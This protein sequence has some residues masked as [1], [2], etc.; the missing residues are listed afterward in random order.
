MEI[1]VNLINS[2]HV[3]YTSPIWEDVYFVISDNTGLEY[4]DYRITIGSSNEIIYRG[5]VY[6]NSHG[7]YPFRFKINDICQDYLSSH[8]ILDDEDDIE[9]YVNNDYLKGFVLQLSSNN[10]NTSRTVA[11]INFRYDWSYI[12][13]TGKN[14]SWVT[15]PI[16]NVVDYRQYF[17][18]SFAYDQSV[19]NNAVITINGTNYTNLNNP[20]ELTF[21]KRLDSSKKDYVIKASYGSYS[22]EYN[23]IDSCK[24]YCLYY[25]NERGGYDWLVID[26]KVVKSYNYQRNYF[27]QNYDSSSKEF[28]KVNYKN[29]ITESWALTT[30]YLSDI[31]SEKMR[32]IF[33]STELYLH[34]LVDDVITPVVITNTEQV[35]KT[36]KNQDRKLYNYTINVQNS[37]TKI[38]M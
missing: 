3:T 18:Y 8:L 38:R 34:D 23:V 16:S 1:S 12:H 2:P 9:F 28:G 25:L 14:V 10:F 21:V 19:A 6:R 4:I 35:E 33:G 30:G 7:K 26:G 22:T 32:N 31:Q 11:T 29:N 17:I 36:F 13:Y 15:N 27:T 24:R 37:Q 20:S 5:K